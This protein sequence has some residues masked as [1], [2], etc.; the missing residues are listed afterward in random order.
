MEQEK[1]AYID[2]E[3][4]KEARALTNQ[5]YVA[6]KSFPKEE[7]FGLVSQMRRSAVS[8]P[9]NIAEGC[10]RNYP[11]DSIQFFFIAR[12][13]IY[14]LETQLYISFDQH[15]IDEVTL[16]SI[17]QKLETTRKLLNGFIKYYQQLV[18]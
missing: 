17:L 12:G 2:L 11:K 1:K 5:V 16:K 10:G 3:V 7:V 4:W 18:K 6:T 9:S 14:E 15:Y 13:S 8:V